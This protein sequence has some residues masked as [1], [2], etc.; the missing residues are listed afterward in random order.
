MLRRQPPQGLR[1]AVPGAPRP[2]H[3]R[4]ARKKKAEDAF[5]KKTLADESL[6]GSADAWSRIDAAHKALA[7]FQK[8][9]SLLEGGNGI[10]SRLFSVARRLVRLA[11]ESA[12]GRRRCRLP[13][14]SDARRASFEAVA[15]LARADLPVELER[16]Q[17]AGSLK[18]SSPKTSAARIR[19]CVQDHGGQVAC[20]PGRRTGQRHQVA[21]RGRAQTPR[22]GRAEGHR[23][24]RRSDDRPG[25]T[26]RPGG[27]G[28]AQALRGRGRGAGAP[29]PGEDRRRPLRAA[30][31]RRAARDATFD[32]SWQ[33][34]R[35][36]PSRATRW[37][38]RN[39]RL[40]RPSRACSPA[41]TSW[42][43]A[44]RLPSCPAAA[45]RP[46]GRSWTSTRRS[47][48][49]RLPT[50]SGATPAARCWTARANSWG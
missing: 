42:R 34:W 8:T 46:Q 27:A 15:V 38:A 36:G 24:E 50:P 29:V 35:S 48:S 1:R 41:P 6:K 3:L 39:C 12:E 21:R 4:R 37:T 33:V 32:A 43:T 28:G 26:H 11:A 2:G 17:L 19:S 10:D 30:G 45:A 40:R 14:Y 25:E 49:S 18:P 16:L 31:H 20:R 5:R 23:R 13:E 7:G 9:Y 44:S 22:R 47:T